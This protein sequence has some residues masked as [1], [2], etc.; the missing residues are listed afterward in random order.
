MAGRLFKKIRFCKEVGRPIRFTLPSL[1][2]NG[3]K[4]SGRLSASSPTSS[5]WSRAGMG[6]RVTVF[7]S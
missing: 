5:S 6:Q 7:I 1:Y 3:E 2:S 4:A